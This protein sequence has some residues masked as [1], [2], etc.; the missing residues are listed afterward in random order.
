M[1]TTKQ[2]QKPRRSVPVKLR[3]EVRATQWLAR[4]PGITTGPAAA[5]TSVA[6]FGPVTT[7]SV[8]AGL[9]VGGLGWARWA[10]DSYHSI[11]APRLRAFGH[12]W[13]RYH[14]RSWRATLEACEL[15]TED[16]RTG[17]VLVPRI[18]HITSPTPSIDV[19][20]VTTVKGQSIRTWRDHQ[21]EL[22][23]ALHA[24]AIGIDRRKPGQ[25]VITLV[26]GNPFAEPIPPTDIPDESEE[27]DLSAVELGETEYGHAWTEPLLGQFLLVHGA[28]GSGK[29][30]LLWN[31]L[32]AIGPLIRTGQARVW[33]IDPK[34]G[35]E[36][37]RARGLFHRYCTTVTA[38]T[39]NEELD[40]DDDQ[41]DDGDTDDEVGAVDLVREFRDDM[42]RAQARLN[43]QGK[44]KATVSRETP[45]NLLMIDE[46]AMLTALA[47]PRA[48][49]ELNRLL[50][51]IMT[52]GR[53]TGH[54]VAA[55]VQEPTKDI[56]PIR[57]L[58]TVRVCLSTTSAN[59]VD[60]VLGDGMREKGALADEI[61]PDEEH[62]GIGY[63]VGE[64]SRMPIR[65]R[66]GY[67]LDE[68]IDELV[69]TCAPEPQSD[70]TA[71]TT[72]VV[73]PIKAA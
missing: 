61:P 28:T 60:A 64:K 12:R 21:D 66:A 36:T 32:R 68:D 29:S 4:H 20:T 40:F 53:A 5:A 25:I 22:A 14:G 13:T 65:V 2:K 51:E 1:K 35:M 16:R 72:D 58:F 67:V 34:G 42:K 70:T 46:L 62:A 30:G 24:D 8:A 59:Y 57:D 69:R 54:A 71:E 17:A 45:F 55:Y 47:E 9:L 49:R 6:Q 38:S 37:S 33:M 19:L 44:R 56:V 11:A 63:R 41:P 10:P 7:G 3:P 73:V 27:V 43:E 50:A 23:E 26:R 18:L 39:D 52:Q 31:P 15:T 48:T